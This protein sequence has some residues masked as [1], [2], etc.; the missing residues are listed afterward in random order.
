MSVGVPLK[1]F[2]NVFTNDIPFPVS[3]ALKLSGVAVTSC[4]TLLLP[5]LF[6]G[7]QKG[8]LVCRIYC[9]GNDQMFFD[10]RL[11]RIV[12]TV[13]NESSV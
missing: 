11:S 12:K 5:S 1:I 3:N 9:L 10:V 4:V 6:V 13:T 7:C 2:V 8:H